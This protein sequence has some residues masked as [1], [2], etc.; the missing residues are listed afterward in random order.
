MSKNVLVISTSPR[1]NSNSESLASAFA[2]GALE[3]GNTVEQISLRGKD[4]KFCIGCLTCVKTLRCVISDDTEEIRQKIADE[5]KLDLVKISPNANPPVCKI[6]DYGKYRYEMQKREKEA[7]KKQK[8]MEVKEVRL[9]PYIESHD[10]NVK[11]KNASK[12]L[13]AGDK[14]KVSIRFRGRERDFTQ[15]GFDVMNSLL[16]VLGDICTVEKKPTME[17][18]HMI[19]ILAPK[20]N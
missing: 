1:K 6:L 10:L 11:A 9:S 7:K 8:T 14:V 18:R 15:I 5:K 12:F 20:N 13:T 16:E 4:I 17:G 2:K 19:M 3:A